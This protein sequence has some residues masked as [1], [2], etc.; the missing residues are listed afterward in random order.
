MST[1]L[2]NQESLYRVYLPH[3]LPGPLAWKLVS[4]WKQDFK[5]VT[6]FPTCRLPDTPCGLLDTSCRLPDASCRAPAPKGGW[7]SEG[8]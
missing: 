3:P 2:G 4:N 1:I 6:L 8:P 5:V 7:Q